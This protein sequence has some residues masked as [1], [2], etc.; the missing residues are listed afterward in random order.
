V[1]NGASI[2][3]ADA[4]LASITVI[5]IIVN[6]VATGSDLWLNAAWRA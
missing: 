5:G 6:F 1:R 3:A 2:H 4:T